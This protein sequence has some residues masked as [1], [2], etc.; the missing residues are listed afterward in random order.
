MFYVINQ[1]LPLRN[2]LGIALMNKQLLVFLFA[3][4]AVD[5]IGAL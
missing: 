3:G 5:D 4:T 2:E 1:N